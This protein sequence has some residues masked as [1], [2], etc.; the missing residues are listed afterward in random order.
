MAVKIDLSPLKQTAVISDSKLWDL[1]S[2][3]YQEL[4]VKW[5][6]NA[7]STG[8]HI[9][10]GKVFNNNMIDLKARWVLLPSLGIIAVVIHQRWSYLFI[11]KMQC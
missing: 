5:T 6:L 10:K 1:V 2:L 11:Y 3:L 8:S 9:I 4:A 7:V